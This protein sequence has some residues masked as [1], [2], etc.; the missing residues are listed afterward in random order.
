MPFCTQCGN[1]VGPADQFCGR[2][3]KR[4]DGSAPGTGSTTTT[5]TRPATPNTDL[6][7]NIAPK[8]AALFCYIPVIGWIPAIAALAAPKFR[9]DRYVRFH[10]FQGIYL[11]VVWLLIDWVVS[12]FLM[13]GHGFDGSIIVRKLLHLA[14]FGG[15]IF[16]L[17][18]ISQ[19]QDYHLPI[20]GELAERS[21]AEQR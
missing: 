9:H 16:M 4:Q 8:T 20:I 11:F 21:L 10:A 12:P 17:I 6:F 18:K 3:G 7:G 19:D 1:Q 2:C 13:V 15:W 14:V 5:S